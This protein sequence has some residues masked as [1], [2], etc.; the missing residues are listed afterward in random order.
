MNKANMNIIRMT[1][2]IEIPITIPMT[3]RS[4]GGVDVGGRSVAL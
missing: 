2:P 1:K 3:K 4:F